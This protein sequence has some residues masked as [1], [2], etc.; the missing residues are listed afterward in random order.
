MTNSHWNYLIYKSS[1]EQ[2]LRNELDYKYVFCFDMNTQ[3]QCERFEQ[4]SFVL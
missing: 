4:Q 2:L 1:R 3:K